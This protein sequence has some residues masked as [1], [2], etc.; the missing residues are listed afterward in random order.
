MSLV[1]AAMLE[2]AHP[3]ACN[4]RIISPHSPLGHTR[5]EELATSDSQSNHHTPEERRR[6]RPHGRTPA[7]RDCHFVIIAP[8]H[9]TRFQQVDVASAQIG[10]AR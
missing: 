7:V 2:G 4:P 8:S 5:L 1:P 3:R 6:L 10:F 9:R